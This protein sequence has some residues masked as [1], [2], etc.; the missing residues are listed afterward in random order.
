M[1]AGGTL[2]I[3]GQTY[4]VLANGEGTNA[5]LTVQNTGSG[6]PPAAPVPAPS[7]AFTLTAT[8]V[9]EVDT[10]MAT[11]ALPSGAALSDHV[12]GSLVT[13]AGELTVLSAY[14]KG[15]PPKLS[16]AVQ[17]DAATPATGNCA[18]YPAYRR[19]IANPGLTATVSVAAGAVG[20]GT[21]D[22][23]A[24]ASD[25]RGDPARLGNEGAVAAPLVVTRSRRGSVASVGAPSSTVPTGQQH[26]YASVPDFDN[27]SFYTLTWPPSGVPRATYVVY[28][29]LD[30][31]LF[32]RDRDQRR[33]RTGPYATTGPFADDSGF[34]TWWSN[35][36]SG[37][38]ISQTDLATAA[39]ALTSPKREQVDQAWKDWAARFYPTLTDT[40][41]Q[42][43]ANRA[44]NESVFARVTSEALTATS[45]ED[46]LDG[47]SASRFLYRVLTVD[48]AGN[49]SPLS[50]SSLPI[51]IPDVVLPV[52]PTLLEAAAGADK[53]T[54][55]WVA[56]IEAKLD[57]Y[58]LYRASS[59][60][61]AEDPR[62]MTLHRRIAKSPSA[63]LR[64]GEVAP[65]AVTGA[66]GRLELDD[67][68]E[69]NS[70]RW[71][72]LVAVDTEGNHSLPSIVMQGM[73][74]GSPPAPIAVTGATWEPTTAG[75]AIRVQWAPKQGVEVRPQRRAVGSSAWLS[76][77]DWVSAATGTADLLTT[78]SYVA[79]EVRLEARAASG[80][81]TVVGQAMTLGPREE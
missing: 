11:S 70:P 58:R 12:G 44:G 28:R 6:T 9:V 60:E 4:Q 26:I 73:A 77:P 59:A 72:R 24:F 69:P 37:L 47:R 52:P 39:S 62:A 10:G 3:G 67:P 43:L 45:Y 1:F 35:Y 19:V 61:D 13:S 33:A 31:A 68:V 79:N 41:I 54:V 22:E 49:Q 66:A 8:D 71:Y 40:A 25:P 65:A 16:F 38:S 50:P 57:H 64:T 51:Y 75:L 14:E 46:A 63:I 81:F 18:W 30:E 55:R 15:T 80:N 2:S 32:L 76:P 36:S 53:I 78:E 27:R 56:N 20:L 29:A 7:G 23:R 17:A 34:S 48:G 21:A 5:A 42:A 74:F